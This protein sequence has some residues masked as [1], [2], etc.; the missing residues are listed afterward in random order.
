MKK[1][2]IIQLF[3]EGGD[4]GDGASASTGEGIS[5]ENSNDVAK[6][7]GIPDRAK[8]YF[9]KSQRGQTK[10]APKAEESPDDDNGKP[11]YEDLIKSDD[12][13]DA[14]KAYMDKTIGDRLKKY[15]GME[16]SYGK[17]NEMLA[18]IAQKYGVD[19]TAENFLDA[20]KEK[21]DADD[22]YY[23][24]YAMEHDITTAEA[25][26][27]VTMER[28]LKEMEARKAME[29]QQ[30]K[31]RQQILILQQN[32]EKTKAQFPEFNLEAE[33]QDERFRR[34][35][36]V[37]G[38]DTTTA[39]VACHHNEIIYNTARMSAQQAQKATANSIAS[40]AKRPTE[41]GVNPIN[42]SATEVDFKGMSLKELRAY[43][44]QQRLKG[45]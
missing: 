14:H 6:S 27:M 43:A 40:G 37:T 38:G 2:F 23:E 12:Y 39:Y 32:A 25:R 16:E 30:E 44:D 22:S 19:S 26:K 33:M 5:G 18:V 8:K 34:M 21:V 1:R 41:N 45:R 31:Q 17:A 11:S 7:L 24:D 4:G 29:E 3:G 15:K 9:E 28:Q 13:K 20:L 10:T 35:C 36:A 42:P